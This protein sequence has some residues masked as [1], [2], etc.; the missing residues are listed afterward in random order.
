MEPAI[1][2]GQSVLVSAIPYLYTKPRIGE[3]VVFKDSKSS[4]TILKRIEKINGDSLKV[5]GDNKTDSRDFGWINTRQIK[6]KVVLF[7]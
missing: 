4:K 6:G 7:L 2:D 1:Y 5:A 3:I